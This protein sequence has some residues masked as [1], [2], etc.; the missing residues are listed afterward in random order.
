MIDYLHSFLDNALST[1][2]DEFLTTALDPE[3]KNFCGKKIQIINESFANFELA[4]PKLDHFSFELDKLKDRA[5]TLKE[6]TEVFSPKDT[7]DV[8]CRGEVITT[9][10]KTLKKVR[11]SK[12]EQIFAGQVAHGYDKDGRPFLD[13]DAKVFTKLL[14]YLSHDRTKLPSDEAAL[15]EIRRLELDKGLATP[16]ALTTQIAKQFQAILD[17][18]PPMVHCEKK[19]AIKAW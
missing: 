18:K 4:A 9:S 17:S 1:K 7:V 5:K 16:G 2:I 11:G 13:C 14:D 19:T 6:F 10:L 3:M 12:L 8:N 15:S